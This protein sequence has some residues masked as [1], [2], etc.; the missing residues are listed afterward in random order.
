MTLYGNRTSEIKTNIG[1]GKYKG[2]L[3]TAMNNNVL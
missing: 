1:K 3:T 2:G